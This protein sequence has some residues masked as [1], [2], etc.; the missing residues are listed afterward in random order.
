[1]ELS[2]TE[3][4]SSAD[5]GGA[6]ELSSPGKEH[7]SQIPQDDA[8]NEVLVP[9]SS[10]NVR[11]NRR[12]FN[13]LTRK[14]HE[15]QRRIQLLLAL[16]KEHNISPPDFSANE[17]NADHIEEEPLLRD[18]L[19][20]LLDGSAE[21][22]TTM[23]EHFK[24][25]V[26]IYKV[27]IQYRDLNFWTMAPEPTI[28]TVGSTVRAI[29]LGTGPKK[30]ADI[31]KGLTGQLKPGR[32]TLVMGP[33]GSGKTT[34]LKAI[35][36]LL[37]VTNPAK[38]DGSI[39]YNGMRADEGKFLVPKLVDY[40]NET[41]VHSAIL[42]VRETLEFAFKANS[43]LKPNRDL[44]SADGAAVLDAM[45]KDMRMVR[46]VLTILGLSGCADTVVGD[47]MLKGIS[48]GQKRRVTLGEMLVCRHSVKCLD[49][50]SNGLDA[51]TTFD[52]NNA[53]KIVARAMGHT[54]VTSLL[55]P[56]PEVF[57]LFDD[58]VLLSQ[59]TLIYHGPRDQ[60]ASYFENLG[61]V[62]PE[63]MDIADFLQELPTREGRRFIS[64]NFLASGG[65]DPNPDGGIAASPGRKYLGVP[66]GT[67]ELAQ[68]WKD[69]SLNRQLLAD[70]DAVD[71]QRV[72]GG[73]VQQMPAS[74]NEKWAEGLGFYFRLLL[75]RQRMVVYRDVGF[76]RA[77]VMQSTIV[78]LIAGSLM[79]NIETTDFQT[80]NSVL[81]FGALNCAMGA[82][83]LLPTVFQQRNVFYKQS[84]A[85]FFP[86]SAFVFAQTVA[87][88]PVLLLE[89]CIFCSILYWWAGLS[90]TDGG[91]RYFTFLTVVIS[92]A[93][94]VGQFY[95]ALGSVLPT[96]QIAQPLCGVSTTIFVLFSGFIIPK[97]S[98]PDGWIWFYYIN[99]VAWALQ[100]VT[101]NEFTAP[102]YDFQVCTSV[103]PSTGACGSTGRFGDQILQSRG[104]S[105]DVS[106]VWTGVGILWVEYL[107]FLALTALALTFVRAEPVPPP[108]I[109]E[110]EL[111]GDEEES[112]GAGTKSVEI[113]FEPVSFA[114]RDVW[115]TVQVAGDELD[116]LKGVNGH[117]EPG[118]VT[119][120]MGSSGAGKTTVSIMLC[121][122]LRMCM[123]VYVATV[124][125]F[126]RL[127]GWLTG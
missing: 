73:D 15:D 90:D 91:A 44:V 29:L 35:S 1:M 63:H 120:L 53:F 108:P 79:S 48:G 37:N 2:A 38:L 94:A 80:M 4:M 13:D 68:S 65:A 121:R 85:Y 116:L 28:P 49:A 31:L 11:A 26:K 57:G 70:M 83:S 87:L 109:I 46:D 45:T 74:A 33:P 104:L 22:M 60:V 59:G 76:L 122:A 93:L 112:G 72:T 110:P 54:V 96:L 19:P 62:C 66:L 34:F 8:Q 14:H 115:Y 103:N 86:A 32:M 77:R 127:V 124:C 43:G 117:C 20:S 102:D 42:T 12:T 101:I 30:R 47:D 23:M 107:V 52:I 119:A 5:K 99:P 97:S 10:F 75:E 51:A 106:E 41:D 111:L 50:I 61:Y 27:T 81:F 126:C 16:L 39:T 123:F 113:Q 36:G 95:R 18:R 55:Q 7:F 58:L 92:L 78:G 100:S 114:F 56:S 67:A 17:K 105:T 3:A 82:M 71:A 84:K 6:I 21:S 118:T 89:T 25:L 24:N 125:V 88:I 98:I 40:V 9:F 64:D 69:S